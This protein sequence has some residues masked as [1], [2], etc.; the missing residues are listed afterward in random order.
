MRA[1]RGGTGH[2]PVEETVVVGPA[3]GEREEVLRRAQIARERRAGST[4]A[5]RT[6]WGRSRRTA[7]S[8][9]GVSALRRTAT[10]AHLE[11]AQRR[12]ERDRLRRG[13]LQPRLERGTRTMDGKRR[14]AITVPSP[15]GAS[16][17]AVD[18]ALQASGHVA[19][20]QASATAAVP[21]SRYRHPASRSPRRCDSGGPRTLARRLGRRPVD[22]SLVI[23]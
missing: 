2:G 16:C 7:R 15:G 8:E 17:F 10:G 6:P 4:S 13:H 1:R 5:P 21:R 14:A 3:G 11:L 20:S 18:L 23:G 19:R 9:L 22:E 12:V